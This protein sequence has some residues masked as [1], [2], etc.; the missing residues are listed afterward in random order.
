MRM[1]YIIYGVLAG[2]FTLCPAIAIYNLRHCD[3]YLESLHQP[4]RRQTKREA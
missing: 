3:G 4:R 1:D 2:I